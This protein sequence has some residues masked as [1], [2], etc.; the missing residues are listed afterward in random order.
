[1]A[2][3]LGVP[4][5]RNHLDLSTQ[6]APLS[7]SHL[8]WS[9]NSGYKFM[10]VDMRATQG[11]S[12]ATAWV[13]HLGS[14]GCVGTAG[15]S[16]APTRCAQPNRAEVS[17]ADFDPSN[18]VVVADLAALLARANVRTNQPKTAAGCMSAPTDSDCGALFAA[19]GLPHPNSTG[20]DTP[21]FFRTMKAKAARAN[22]TAPR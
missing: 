19:L 17:F 8:F 3:T 14:T 7:L 21:A 11:D 13:I 18:D 4:A 2:F 20:A 12:A 6:P 9:W 1:M 15:A 10:R 16:A 22:T 5:S